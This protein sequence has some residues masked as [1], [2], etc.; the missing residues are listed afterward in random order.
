MLRP[1]SQVWPGVVLYIDALQVQVTAKKSLSIQKVIHTNCNRM[2]MH[3][4]AVV[5]VQSTSSFLEISMDFGSF[6]HIISGPVL[7]P[8]NTLHRVAFPQF[9]WYIIGICNCSLPLNLVNNAFWF[10]RLYSDLYYICERGH[11]SVILERSAFI[12]LLRTLA[13]NVSKSASSSCMIFL[14]TVPSC[15]WFVLFM[16]CVYHAFA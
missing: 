9:A 7:G 3:G 14:L 15:G 13:R 2:D 12:P 5:G 1:D 10:V 11:R 6:L 8:R 16:S 4:I